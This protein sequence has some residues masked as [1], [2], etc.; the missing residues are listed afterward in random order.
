MSWNSRLRP[1]LLAFLLLAGSC[2]NVFRDFPDKN[3]DAYLLAKARQHLDLY[4]FDRAIE[5]V[6][7]VRKRHPDDQ[8]V[9]N[10]SIVSYAG[11][12]GL[13]SLD[14]LFELTDIGDSTFF[15]IF[16]EHFPKARASDVSDMEKA[17][18]LY[19]GLTD[20]A[21]ERDAEQ[22]LLGLFLYMGRIGVILNHYGYD[23]N[24]AQLASFDACDELLLPEVDNQRIMNSVPRLL[25]TAGGLDSS[26]GL[27]EA[28]QDLVSSPLL[29]V[30]AASRDTDC[31]TDN[32]GCEG[33]RSLIE[34]GSAGIG[35][36]AGVLTPCP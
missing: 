17:V 33:I 7:I 26:N 12:A 18:S 6:E 28:I 23:D 20:D 22:N 14:L 27:G 15:R 13:R 11:R 2:A 8:D 4:E 16:A 36:G 10:L 19:E 21:D 3:G 24:N 9:V 29:S 34:E 31:P 30:F 32:V 35:I 1:A 5:A 25:E